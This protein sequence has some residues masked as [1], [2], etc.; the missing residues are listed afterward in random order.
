MKKI[1]GPSDIDEAVIPTLDAGQIDESRRHFAKAGLA[2]SGVILT[3]ASQPVLG[4]AS[5]RCTISGN[6]SGN[7]SRT[8]VTKPCNSCGKGDDYWEP[9]DD[10]KKKTFYD[11]MGSEYSDS[12]DSTKDNKCSWMLK[13]SYENFCLKKDDNTSKYGS[14]YSSGYAAP[15]Q[16]GSYPSKG[17]AE[18]KKV[19]RQE[20]DNK[21][22][23]AYKDVNTKG[24]KDGYFDSYMTKYSGWGHKTEQ[25]EYQ[26]GYREGYE[27]RCREQYGSTTNH[28]RG[29][30]W[31]FARECLVSM[32]NCKIKCVDDYGVKE[33]EVKDMWNAC[34]SGGRY[35][36][37]PGVYWSRTECMSYLKQLHT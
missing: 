22:P 21:G 28:C 30:G 6:L 8:T 20:V 7:L 1:H 37:R 17:Y 18:G 14:G 3:L 29:V 25:R 32:L 5:V 19:G 4:S 31:D 33:R 26:R 2:G 13:P 23:S 27:E 10:C 35:Q 15:S 9:R 11:Y 16:S 36:V 34:K 24:K 12:R